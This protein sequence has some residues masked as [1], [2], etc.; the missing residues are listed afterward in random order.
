[1]L[2]KD[3][4]FAND[5]LAVID[6]PAGLSVLADRSSQLCLW[7]ELKTRYSDRTIYQVHRLDK[8]TSGLLLVAFTKEAQ[9]QLN[10][11]F[12]YHTIE[13]TYL[14]IC[15]GR[16]APASGWI[17]LPLCPGRKNGFRVAGQRETIFLDTAADLP[18]WKLPASDQSLDPVRKIYPAQTFY[19]TVWSDGEYSLL[20]VKPLTGRTHQ[21]RVHLAWLGHQIIGDPLYGK[22][23]SSI[24]QAGRM[25]LHSSNIQFVENWLSGQKP[26]QRTFRAVLPTFFRDFVDQLARQKAISPPDWQ[27]DI[28]AESLTTELST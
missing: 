28:A 23:Q 21:I 26:V 19:R 27:N 25:A 2:D 9:A 15:V 22:P 24:Q 1:M 10:R 12:F 4:L 6:K 20:V 17:D 5:D 13:K 8:E 11:Q 3:I 18:T 14:A 7:D 16:P